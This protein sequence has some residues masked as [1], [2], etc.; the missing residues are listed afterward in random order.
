MLYISPLKALAV[1]V[2]RNLRA[3]LAGIANVA[4]PQGVAVTMPADR[5]PDRRHAGQ[6]TRAVSARA[7]GH[8]DHHARVAVPAADVERP[9]AARDGRHGH[10]RRDSRARARQARRAP[11]AVARAAGG[12]AAAGQAAL[13]R[14]LQRIGLS[15]TQRPLDEVARFLGGAEARAAPKAPAQEAGDG[16]K[17]EAVRARGSRSRAPRRVRDGR[18]A[19]RLPPGHHRQRLGEEAAE[20][21]DRSAGRGHGARWPRRSTCRAARQS[22]GPAAIRRSGR[23]STRGCWS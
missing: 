18:E 2:E 13:S 20:A 9:R 4:Q 10:H 21:A 6:R 7:G 22:Q 12:A 8:P 11:G 14:T 16:A 19:R 3:P 23:R 17:A 5:H 15:A 1:D